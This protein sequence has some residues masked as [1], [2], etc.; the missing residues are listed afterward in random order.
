MGPPRRITRRADDPT[1]RPSGCLPCRC[2]GPPVR[3]SRDGQRNITNA[4]VRARMRTPFGQV[5]SQRNVRATIAT[6]RSREPMWV[7]RRTPSVVEQCSL[8]GR[9]GVIVGVPREVKDRENR[10]S[11]TPAGAREYVARGHTILVE[12][13]AGAGSG[14][15]DVEYSAAGAELVATH[16]EVFARAA[17]IVKVKEPVASEYQL[18]R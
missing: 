18:M 5:R 6:I 10:V 9:I 13:A 17:M 3:V 4:G 2:R 14:F 8:S 16:E 15:L 12:K 11:T 7:R 1:L